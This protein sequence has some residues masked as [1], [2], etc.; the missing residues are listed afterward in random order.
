[1][2]PGIVNI[3]CSHAV[4]EKMICRVLILHLDLISGK[5]NIR[6]NPEYPIAKQSVTL[7]VTGITGRIWFFTW[8]KG[9]NATSQYQIVT[10]VDDSPIWGTQY[11]SRVSVFSNGSL[12][13][14]DLHVEDGGNY[15]VKV[16]AKTQEDADIFLQ[17]YETVSKP[18]IIASHSEIKENDFV[19]LICVSANADRIIWINSSSETLNAENGNIVKHDNGT[20]IFSK[21]RRS[22]EG[23][24]K[25]QAENLVSR[26][27]SEVYTLTIASEENE[28]VS[29][30]PYGSTVVSQYITALT[31]SKPANFH[32]SALYTSSA[33]TAGIVSGT[34]LGSIL[35]ILASF[36]LYKRYGLCG[37][38]QMTGPPTDRPDSYATYDSILDPSTSLEP[39]DEPLYMCLQFSSEGTYNELQT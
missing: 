24:Y 33:A 32:E 9:L 7:S 39:K 29:K 11:F 22:N 35:I 2:A 19:S 23:K 21:I 14:K 37:R 31:D 10:Y 5:I 27:S 3:T 30:E 13:I 36:L 25:C 15:R 16:Q 17:V 18:V 1:M 20:I 38:K 26:S 28:P 4:R 34:I 6:L 12:L 8:F